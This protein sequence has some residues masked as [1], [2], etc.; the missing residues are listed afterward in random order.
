M[1][2]FPW[3]FKESFIIAFGLIII[4]VCLEVVTGDQ[5]IEPI[6]YP[7]NVYVGIAFI[8]LLLGTYVFFRKSPFIR[9]LSSVPAAISAISSLALLTLLM[10][11]IP[12]SDSV[13]PVFRQF[14]LTHLTKSWEFL[15][16]IVYFQF[17]LGM[18]IL[19]RLGEFRLK[20]ASFAFN[21]IGLWLIVFAVAFG[22]G[23]LKRWNM[24]LKEGEPIW[25][26]TDEQNQRRELDFALRLE[27]FHIEHYNPK[28]TLISTSNYSIPERFQDQQF[29]A[30]EDV[31]QTI[32]EWRIKVDTFYTYAVGHGNR[33]YPMRME[34]ASYAAFVEAENQKSGKAEKG[35]I[36]PG[37]YRMKPAAVKLNEQFL[38]TLTQPEHKKYS[39][40]MT[41]FIKGEGKQEVN[42][43]VNNPLKVNGWKIYQQSYDQQKGRWSKESIL[44]IV[45]DP[46]LPVVY[47]GIFFLMAGAL[48]LFWSGRR[49]QAS[50]TFK[51]DVK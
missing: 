5:E 46:W 50:E 19:K 7:H 8:F 37:S 26:A 43:A 12:Q 20:D 24:H 48:M 40:R 49:K 47:A 33:Y 51:E 42:L 16:I 6:Q 10:G 23:D 28:I 29:R 32:G 9:W 30:K 18:T 4:G 27:D 39:S 38:L 34:G 41:L 3:K 31:Q 45:K 25:Y 44:E 35:W 36:S 14:G 1:W 13:H 17:I 2:K 21:H 11:F 15:F 22:R